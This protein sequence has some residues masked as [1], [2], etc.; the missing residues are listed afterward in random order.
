LRGHAALFSLLCGRGEKV[1]VTGLRGQGLRAWRAEK[2]WALI[3]LGIFGGGP[4]NEAGPQP[5][6]VSTL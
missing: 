5:Q 3:Q 6:Y 2:S 4:R 1:V